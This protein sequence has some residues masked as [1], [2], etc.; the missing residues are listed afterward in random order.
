MS[1]SC[2]NEESEQSVVGAVLLQPEIWPELVVEV[3]SRDFFWPIHGFLWDAFGALDAKKHPIDHLTVAAELVRSGRGGAI[4]ARPGYIDSLA[5]RCVIADT[6]PYHARRV[7]RLAERRRWNKAL[8][9]LS[10][11]SVDESEGDDEFFEA[12]EATLLSL[13]QQRR[14]ARTLISSKQALRLV[15]NEVERRYE[16]RD[17]PPDGICTGFVDFDRISYGL[18]PGELVILAARPSVGKS[19]FMGNVAEYVARDKKP[20]LIFSLEMSAMALFQRMIAA[21]GVLADRLRTGRMTTTDFLSMQRTASEIATICGIHVDE[22]GDLTIAELRSRARRWRA[23]EGKGDRALVCVDYLQLVSG[24]RGKQQK[25]EEE[26]AEVS[27]GLKALAKELQ[28]PVLALAQLNREVEKRGNKRPTLA[29]LRESGQIEQDADIAAFLYREEVS[30]PECK[31]EDRG[32]AELIVAKGR[33]MQ[34]GTVKLLFQA[35]YQRFRARA[36]DSRGSYAH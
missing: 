31:P 5:A 36:A 9:E 27:R 6:A 22:S 15:V 35:E 4:D 1:W 16:N 28:C 33:D 24:T 19:A 10:A 18:K 3:D 8:R 11:S 29:D 25:R 26:V 34:V 12:S 32:T 13:L 17:K 14:S 20:V 7:A 2:A 21:G 30:N 23:N